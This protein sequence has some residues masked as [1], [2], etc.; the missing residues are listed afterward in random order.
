MYF[1]IQTYLAGVSNRFCISDSRG[2][3][4]GRW[5]AKVG[6]DRPKDRK[7]DRRTGRQID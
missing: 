3:S 5:L 2:R 7:T 1:D 4:V 6:T